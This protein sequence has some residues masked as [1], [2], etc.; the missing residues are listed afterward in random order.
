ML[1][2]QQVFFP[3]LVSEPADALYHTAFEKTQVV[4]E[5]ELDGLN[6]ERFVMTPANLNIERGGL[7][8]LRFAGHCVHR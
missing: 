4:G 6:F 2:L 8:T 5:D 7:L 3:V 1:D